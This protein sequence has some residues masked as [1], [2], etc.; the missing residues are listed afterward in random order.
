MVFS[1]ARLGY[2]YKKN[3]ALILNNECCVGRYFIQHPQLGAEQIMM[4]FLRN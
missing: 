2:V 3:A 1:R 4:L